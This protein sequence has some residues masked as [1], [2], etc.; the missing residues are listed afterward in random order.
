MNGFIVDITKNA[1]DTYQ[2][3][4]DLFEATSLGSFLKAS[5]NAETTIIAIMFMIVPDVFCKIY[6]F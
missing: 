4:E 1:I 6:C 3:L 2:I 5:P